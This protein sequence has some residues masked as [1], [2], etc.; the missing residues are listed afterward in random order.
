MMPRNEENR[1]VPC[2]GGQIWPKF[3][4]KW[5]NCGKKTFHHG[6]H[7]VSRSLSTKIIFTSVKL[8]VVKIL[9]FIMLCQALL[10]NLN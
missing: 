9:K 10:R 7:G 8:S 2:S 4:H 1:K 3:G 6:G 5:L